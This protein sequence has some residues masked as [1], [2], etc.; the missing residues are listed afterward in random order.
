MDLKFKK[1]HKTADF[2]GS[3]V[4]KAKSY[5]E[6]WYFKHVSEDTNKTISFIPGVSMNKKDPHCFVQCIY[7]GEDGELSTYY[8]RYALYEFEFSPEPFEIRVGDCIFTKNDS[9]IS[10]DDGQIKIEGCFTYGEMTDIVRTPLMPNIMGFFSYIPH[11]E[12]NHEVISMDHPIEGAVTINNKVIDWGNG[13]GYIE[14]DWGRSFPRNY[15]WV[16]SNNFDEDSMSFI[17]SVA[18]IPFMG[19]AF[20]GYFCNLVVDGVEYRFATYNG[21]RL[22][23]IKKTA[24]EFDIMLVNRQVKIRVKGKI[25]QSGELKSPVN[26]GMFSTIKEGLSGKVRIMMKDRNGQLLVNA[27]SQTCGIELEM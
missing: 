1:H 18:R 25:E 24:N 20:E 13:K 7:K 17:L 9:S 21:S 15:L 3:S 16:Q 10:L 26:G 2:Q 11:M 14:K 8:Y 27:K 5:F 6:G 12:C 23:V 22:K 4:S 19:L